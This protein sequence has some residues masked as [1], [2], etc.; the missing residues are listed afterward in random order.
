MSLINK[1][2]QDLDARG[3]AG[4]GAMP[5]E[6]KPVARPERRFG[7]LAIAALVAVLVIGLGIA[8]AVGWRMMHTTAREVAVVSHAPAPVAEAE[9]LVTGEPIGL[10]SA[11]AAPAPAPAAETPGVAASAG[12]APG[13]DNAGAKVVTNKKPVA[14]SGQAVV[15][16]AA[17]RKAAAQPG[18]GTSKPAKP[19]ADKKVAAAQPRAA[20]AARTA[21]GV[22][23]AQA[24]EG[25]YRKA[26]ASLAEGRIH[27]ALGGLQQALRLHPRHEAARQTL[28]GLLIEADRPDDAMRQLQAA[29][30]LEPAQPTLAMLL[31]R[32]QIER[33]ESGID[34]LT[35]TL[36][37]AGANGEYRAFLAGALVRAQRHDE[38]SEH[39]RAALRT[40]PHNG[41]W[42]MGLGIALQAGKRNGEAIEAFQN[43][44]SAGNLSPELDAFVERKLQQLTR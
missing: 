7:P 3:T 41:V 28:V 17:K 15:A 37:Y 26:L 1:M 39:Y 14:S 2:L 43:A 44:R 21:P 38:A 4:T 23:A 25:A 20:E 31:A 16:A 36:P 40:A 30:T 8:G 5:F 24:A 13:G 27:E 11:P 22:P 10:A 6:V 9:P 32:L 18:S 35:R 19:S 12:S 29:L 34:T 33:G 42:W